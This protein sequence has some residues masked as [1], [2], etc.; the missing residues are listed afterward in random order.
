V[1]EHFL[2]TR[3]LAQYMTLIEGMLKAEPR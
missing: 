3:H 2:G 1:L